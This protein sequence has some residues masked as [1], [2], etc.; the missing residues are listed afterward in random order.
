MAEGGPVY[1]DGSGTEWSKDTSDID[2][3]ALFRDGG[4]TQYNKG[5]EAGTPID[6]SKP[7][8]EKVDEKE[9]KEMDDPTLAV[10]DYYKDKEGKVRKVT[11]IKY[12]TTR[13]NQSLSGSENYKPK[14]GDLKADVV[15]ANEIMDRLAKDGFADC[16]SYSPELYYHNL[17]NDIVEYV[18]IK[19]YFRPYVDTRNFDPSN[20]F[21]EYV[22]F[23][24]KTYS[25]EDEEK[26][27]KYPVYLSEMQT[28]GYR[29]I[30]YEVGHA[31]SDY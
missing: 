30:A 2:I 13:V 20:N 14:Y 17:I 22:I 8:D 27:I 1:T 10:G 6:E 5:G 23:S 12:N 31:L 29:D 15:K 4:Q 21:D 16:D 25:F 11:K 18:D 19:F 26:D 28:K 7:A 9:V 3:P 24:K